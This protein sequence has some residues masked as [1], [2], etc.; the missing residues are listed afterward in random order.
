MQNGKEI[1]CGIN[2][3]ITVSGVKHF[4]TV[5]GSVT[6][7][8]NYIRSFLQLNVLSQIDESHPQAAYSAHANGLKGKFTYSLRT[9]SNLELHMQPI[10]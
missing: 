7:R 6:L 5:I 3:N 2:I 1:F 4:G 9:I 10:E 8:E